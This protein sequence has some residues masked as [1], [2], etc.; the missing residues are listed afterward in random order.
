[1]SSILYMANCDKYIQESLFEVS[2]DLIIL[3]LRNRESFWLSRFNQVQFFAR[4][5]LVPFR[6]YGKNLK[7]VFSSSVYAI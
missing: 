3:L 4:I 6:L 7:K 1:M 5:A 2:K